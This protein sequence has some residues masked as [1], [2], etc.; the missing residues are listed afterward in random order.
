MAI[1]RD[2]VINV[3]E[4]GIDELQ[5]KVLKLD[6]SLENLEDTNKNLS[7]TRDGT[8]Q[9]VLDNGGAMG[10]LNDATGG[11]AMTVK[12]AVEASALFAKE[13][14]VGMAVQK[15]YTLV[16][17]SSTGAM[18]VFKLALIG[19]GIGAIVI[20]IGLLIANFG[21]VKKAVMDLVPGLKLVGAFFGR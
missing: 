7:K 6:S 21:K 5:S 2:I 20:A 3:K 14:K 13:S 19:T 9:S 4:K 8:Q 18:K 16:M 10:L 17:G 12:D 11:L 15:A 1:E